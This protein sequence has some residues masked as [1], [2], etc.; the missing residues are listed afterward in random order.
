MESSDVTSFCCGVLDV[1]CLWNWGV[2]VTVRVK[3]EA[4]VVEM[5]ASFFVAMVGVVLEEWRFVYR[6][7]GDMFSGCLWLSIFFGRGS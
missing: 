7:G 5:P 3:Q 2:K 1:W 4:D 6:C